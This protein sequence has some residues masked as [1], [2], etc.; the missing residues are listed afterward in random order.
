M[1]PRQKLH[2]LA[3]LDRIATLA[4]TALMFLL[5]ACGPELPENEDERVRVVC[6]SCHVFPAPGV[7]P[8]SVW[9]TQIEQM[10]LL[11]DTLPAGAAVAHFDVEAF[12]AWYESRAPDR[13]LMEQPITRAERPP[14]RFAFRAIRLGKSSGSGVA[15]VSRVGSRLAVPNMS[16]GS[17]HLLSWKTGP[18]LLGKAEHPARVSLG[19]LDGN[20]LDDLLIADLG[21]MLPTDEPTGRVL[22]ALQEQADE[23]ELQTLAHTIGRVADVRPLDLDRDGDLDLVVAAFG[24]LLEGGVYV[25]HN[26]SAS[27]RLDFRPER[28]I[29]RTGAVSVIPVDGLQPGTGPGFVVAFA[30]QHE[31]VSLFLPRD[32]GGYEERVLYRAP[33]PAWGT[34]NLTEADLDADGDVDFLL[35]NGDTL[36]DGVA[37]KPYHGVTWLENRGAEGFLAQPIGRLYGANSAEAGDLDG[38]GDLDIVASGFL[39]Q[40]ELPVPADTIRLDSVVW[41]ERDGDAWI[42]WEIESGHPR[43]TGVT[44]FDLD[45]DGRLDIVAAVNRAWDAAP[46]ETGPSLE[47]WLNRGPR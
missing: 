1:K 29:A 32:S 8:R 26:E 5:A 40:V 17:I 7:L 15:T 31:M 19:D 23:Y 43:H 2:P 20:G 27:G 44:L 4:A 42:P 41:F 30:Q 39:P 22:V 12:V 9:R 33:H 10:A 28:V 18:R 13:L 37:I 21:N 38:D 47:V 24:Y 45:E 46:T 6:S 14:L 16:M 35:S 11:V 34:S 25:L 3:R 36:D